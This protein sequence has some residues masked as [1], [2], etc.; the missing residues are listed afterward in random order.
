MG[1]FM[2]ARFSA[3]LFVLLPAIWPVAA[4]T[5]LDTTVVLPGVT[6]TAAR[7]QTP[8][9]TAPVRVTV[10]GPEAIAATGARSVA[11]LLEARAGLFVKR[12]GDG[13]LATLSLRGT[14]AAQTLVLVDGHRIADPQLGQLDLNL[15]PTILL[16]GVE[17]M[18]GAGSALYGTDGLGGVVNLRTVR[19]GPTPRARLAGGLGAYGERQGSLLLSGS[20]GRFSATAAAEYSAADG[21]F[22]YVNEALFPPR[23]VRRRNAD[24]ARRALYATLGHRGDTHRTCLAAWINDA[25]QGLP[26]LASA[27]PRDERQWDTNL[28]LWADHERR[29]RGR[30]LRLGGLVQHSR[31]RY[32]HPGLQIDDTGRTLL[33]SAEAE[34]QALA[35]RRW[36]LAGGLAGGFGQA[37]HPNLAEQARD[38]HAG[39]FVHGTGHY[40]RLRLYPALRLD[41]YAAAQGPLRR[42]V[43]PRLGLNLQPSPALPL[44]LKAGAGRSFRIP[45]FNDRFWQPGGNP[46][47]RPEH[48]WTVDAGLMAGT[49]AV[50]AEVTAFATRI[51]DQIVWEPTRQGFWSP[52]N[53]QRVRTRGLEA[54]LRA[55]RPLAPWLAL[56]GHAFYTLTDARDRSAPDTPAYDQPLRYVPRHQLKAGA[57]LRLGPLRLD[58]LARYIGRRYLTTDG[59]QALD[60]LRALD[61]RLRL[62]LPMG[63]ATATLALSVYNLTDQHLEIIKGYPL[64]PRHARLQLTL[65]AGGR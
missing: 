61:G 59:R 25:E 65:D 20:R 45:T 52:A 14:G 53:V 15:L 56:G 58:L 41:V 29:R 47:L 34:V 44:Y 39:A 23:E 33:A 46:D 43:S 3:L 63:P 60:P 13:G 27:S 21:D 19:P 12:Y 30:T 38:G 31:L 51:T 11:D 7:S 26:G 54:S 49:P 57:G 18:H 32:V 9:T 5:P 4:Q 37:A 2:H 35:G 50:Q 62:R 36:L 28:R 17:V 22:P 6:V 42:A 48:G 16:D 40:D 10:L 64:P 24:R 55:D 8:T 1:F